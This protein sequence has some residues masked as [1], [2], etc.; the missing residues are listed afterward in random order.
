MV[1]KE[2]SKTLNTLVEF[3]NKRKLNT[4]KVLKPEEAFFPY[5]YAIARN[6]NDS[7]RRLNHT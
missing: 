5:L 7:S 1:N 3:F 2:A 6:D 4:S